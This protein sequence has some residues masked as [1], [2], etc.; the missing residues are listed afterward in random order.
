MKILFAI[1][2]QSV[3]NPYIIT[4]CEKLKMHNIDVR[5]SL[6]ELWSCIENYDIIHFQ[7]PEAIYSWK[8]SIST[9]QAN[10]LSMVL[11]K[12][13]ENGTKI[14]ITCHNLRPHTIIDKN[15]I[16]LYNII[17]RSCD[18]FLHMGSYSLHMLKSQYPN[19]KHYILPHHTYDTI[20]KFE[21][22]KDLCRN[23]L[24]IPENYFCILCFGE[25]RTDQERNL[26]LDLKNIIPKDVFFITPGFFRQKLLSKHP[27]KTIQNFIKTIKYRRKGIEFNRKFINIADTEK[28]F[29]ATD[30]V[31]IQRIDILNS[32]NLPMAFAAGKVVIGPDTGN[33]GEILKQTGNPTF[34]PNNLYSI[35]DA[36]N[37]A[38]ELV[39]SGKG[40]WNKAYAEKH[41][42]TDIIT[43]QLIYYYNKIL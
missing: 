6:N 15:V 7:W 31:M 33:V 22:Q 16:S 34:I 26:I 39:S 25:F 37:K 14:A 2:S 10:K 19:A 35:I 12:A 32:G 9:E 24:R 3:S 23:Y 20:Y 8:R 13:K 30:I 18:L 38:Q 17:Y 21:R 36:I 42:T 11:Q 5:I 28:Y 27:I 1:D 29:C 41:W 43:Q 40:Q 4:L